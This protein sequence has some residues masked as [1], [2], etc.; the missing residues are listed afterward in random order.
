MHGNH[1]PG[2]G[3]GAFADKHFFDDRPLAVVI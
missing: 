2:A 3:L 1:L